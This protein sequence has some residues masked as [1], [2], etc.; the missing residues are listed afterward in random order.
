MS[1]KPGQEVRVKSLPSSIDGKITKIL[2]EPDGNDSVVIQISIRR[3]AS[4]LEL[5]PT[6][7]TAEE[8]SATEARRAAAFKAWEANPSDQIESGNC[9]LCCRNSG[10]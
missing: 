6:S 3:R 5:I 8:V 10:G 9:D 1:L 7:P 2:P 4:D